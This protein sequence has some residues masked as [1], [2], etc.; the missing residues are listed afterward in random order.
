MEEFKYHKRLWLTVL[1][2]DQHLLWDIQKYLVV[3]IAKGVLHQLILLAHLLSCRKMWT[4]Q[5][6]ISFSSRFHWSEL[7]GCKMVFCRCFIPWSSKT[8]ITPNYNWYN[9]CIKKKRKKRK[10]K[11]KKTILE[12]MIQ[13]I[14]MVTILGGTID[15]YLLLITNS[16]KTNIWSYPYSKNN[17]ELNKIQSFAKS[18]MI[19]AVLV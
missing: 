9:F 7:D 16:K 11:K 3:Y 15:Y 6:S 1:H 8:C 5:M 4:T 18:R 10:E 2:H 13:L 17:K 12:C 14:Q 19:H